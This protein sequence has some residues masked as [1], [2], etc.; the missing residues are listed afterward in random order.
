MKPRVGASVLDC[1]LKLYYVRG[2]SGRPVPTR[3]R[4]QNRAINSNYGVDNIGILKYNSSVFAPVAELAALRL[5]ASGGRLSE[6]NE[7]KDVYSAIVK[8]EDSIIGTI[9]LS[10]PTTNLSYWGYADKSLWE[11]LDK[12]TNSK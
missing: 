12:Y 5:S 6:H 9:V 2:Q 11:W 4:Q 8:D 1:P 10:M 7:A 3:C